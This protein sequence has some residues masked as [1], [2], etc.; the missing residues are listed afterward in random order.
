MIFFNPDI[1]LVVGYVASKAYRGGK[2]GR[3]L[4]S[5]GLHDVNAQRLGH[6]HLDGGDTLQGVVT[7]RSGTDSIVIG[8]TATERLI[9]HET[10]VYGKLPAPYPAVLAVNAERK[11]RLVKLTPNTFI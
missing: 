6:L 9:A 8:R 4:E 10:G 1:A 7:R 5:L 11:L 3:H 2:R